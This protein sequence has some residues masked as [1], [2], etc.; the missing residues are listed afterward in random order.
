LKIA[1]IRQRYNPYGGAERFV[2]RAMAA[3]AKQNV[4][5]TL[6]ARAWLGAAEAAGEVRLIRCDPFYIGRVWRDWGFARSICATLKTNAFDLVQSHERI[7]CCDVY[8][9]GDGVH[10]QWLANRARAAGPLERI[11]LALN[12]Y[13]LYVKAAEKRLF[14]SSRLRAVICNS[15]MVKEEVRRHFGLPEDKLHVIYNGVDLAAFNPRLREEWRTRKRAELG[16]G[17]SAMVFLFVGSGFARKGLP[18]LLRAMTGVRGA[19]LIVVGEDRDLALMQSA[20]GDMKLA[21]RVHFAGAQKDVKSWYGMADCFVLPTLYDPFP[22]AALEAMASGLPLITTMQCGAAEFVESGVEGYI[23]RDA[24]N[25]VELARCLN[26]AAA[27]GQ[28]LR[29]GAAARRRVEPYGLDAMAL[30]LTEL[31]ARLIEAK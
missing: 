8:R 19:H 5:M 28:A 4:E 22:N 11:A 24:L 29:M 7:A 10:R 26:L 14:E 23:C 15:I 12:P 25:V 6:F 27:P 2:E 3:L 18:Q 16:L 30:K 17:D 31:Y 9:A 20:A 1:L 13:H 21:D